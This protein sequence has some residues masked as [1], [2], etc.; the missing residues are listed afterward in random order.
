MAR[1]ILH[2]C[3]NCDFSF[4]GS[5]KP[6]ALMR[7]KTIPVV[8]NSCKSIYDRIIEPW[9]DEPIP[10]CKTCG[11]NDYTKWDCQKKSCPK[12]VDGVIGEEDGGTITMAD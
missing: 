9:T 2:K 11:D 3:N 5:G 7:G 12:C 10:G 8:C 4:I 6:D 1:W